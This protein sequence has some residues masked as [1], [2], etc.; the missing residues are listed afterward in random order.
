MVPTVRV[1][2]LHVAAEQ[3]TLHMNCCAPVLPVPCNAVTVHNSVTLPY[4]SSHH[5][6]SVHSFQQVII[7]QM[8]K[9]CFDCYNSKKNYTTER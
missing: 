4:S 8:Y 3:Y 5:K 1:L 6:L 7:Q 2:T 9:L